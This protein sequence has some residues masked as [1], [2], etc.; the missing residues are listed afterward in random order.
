MQNN[1]NVAPSG[2]K[3][4]RRRRWP[5]VIGLLALAGG[6]YFAWQTTMASDAGA[7]APDPAPVAQPALQVMRLAGVD[8]SQVAPATLTRSVKVT[9]TTHPLQRADL[10]AQVA[11][12]VTAVN[13]RPGDQ[14]KSGD[15][16]VQQD[17]RDLEISLSQVRANMAATQVQ[18]ELAERQLASTRALADQQ[19]SSTNSLDSA[20]S[21]VNAQKA[22][23]AALEAQVAA[24]QSSIDKATIRAP[25]DG[26]ISARSVEPNQTLSPGAAL[27]T[28]V[29]LSRIE[30]QLTAPLGQAT[31][32]APGQQVRLSVENDRGR[33]L[34]GTVDR[35]NPVALEG[36]RSIGLYATLNNAEGMLRGGMFVTGEVVTASK[37]AAIGVPAAAIQ[38]DGDG[39]FVLKVEGETVQRQPVEVGG[40]WGAS[41]TTEIVA[42]LNEGDLI[43]N[44][45]LERLQP[46]MNVAVEGQT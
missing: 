19:I 28:L 5:L 23:L 27:V 35:V 13:F 25:F 36:T 31:A 20:Q 29:D 4:P 15:I 22:Q 3:P 46:G 33:L 42:G 6:G 37:E 40:V 44:T 34:T 30:V 24:A 18:L 10:T 7:P 11:G 32:L 2:G 45:R 12:V 21:A 39:R 8:V 17:I 26:V 9:G 1:D 14:V 38:E 41:G 43:V 16:I